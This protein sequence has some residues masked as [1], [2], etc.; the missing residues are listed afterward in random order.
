M[1]KDWAVR[2]AVPQTW[3]VAGR[4]TVS[5]QHTNQRKSLVAYLSSRY[6]SNLGQRPAKLLLPNGY[7][8][9]IELMI[10][11]MDCSHT[12][13]GSSCNCTVRRVFGS[14]PVG[15]GPDFVS[16]TAG[17]VERGPPDSLLMLTMLE[18]C[19]AGVLKL[20]LADRRFPVG[21]KNV[22][23]LSGP[24]QAL[25]KSRRTVASFS[26]RPTYSQLQIVRRAPSSGY[27]RTFPP[28]RTF[29]TVLVTE[30]LCIG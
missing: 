4:V 21:S 19:Q 29:E 10:G 25:K 22:K 9:G 18:A 13:K 5:L 7:C 3:R 30:R 8:D 17:A 12:L 14:A 15:L 2:R 28:G 11:A 24:L 27:I 23:D 6:G 16:V 1:V 26:V 20:E